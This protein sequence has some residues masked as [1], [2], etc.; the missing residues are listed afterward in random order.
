MMICHTLCSYSESLQFTLCTF[1]LFLFSFFLLSFFFFFF[2]LFFF[3]SFF[4][5]SLLF[6]SWEVGLWGGDSCTSYC[7]SYIVCES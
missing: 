5:F 3:S 6:F 4:R 7:L 2:F 1:S